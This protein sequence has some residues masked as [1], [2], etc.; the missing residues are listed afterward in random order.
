VDPANIFG[1][2]RNTGNSGIGLYASKDS[3]VVNN[4]IV[5]AAQTNHSAIY[6]G[7]AFQDWGSHPGRPANVNPKIQNNLVIQNNNRCV[8]IRYSNELGGLSGLSGSP[9]TDWNGYNNGCTF[10]DSRPGSGI[11]G[12]VSL[13]QWRAAR[14][15][16]WISTIAPALLS[17]RNHGASHQP[18]PSGLGMVRRSSVSGLGHSHQATIASAVQEQTA[19]TEEIARSLGEAANGAAEIARSLA[20][21]STA[22][23]S[24]STAANR[25]RRTAAQLTAVAAELETIVRGR[26]AA[27]STPRSRISSLKACFIPLGRLG[28]SIA[29]RVS[30]VPA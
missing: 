17:A 2:V 7:V 10:R 15:T 16:G 24:T 12:A 13:A 11:S 25:S 3:V 6:F 21:V 28:T 19:T 27:G 8:E 30:R 29:S 4:T 14:G 9:G 20:T 5:N 18:P 22:A 1:V 23:T 26:A